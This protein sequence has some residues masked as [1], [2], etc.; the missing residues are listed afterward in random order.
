MSNIPKTRIRRTL[1]G[2]VFTAF[3]GP[4]RHHWE[5]TLDGTTIAEFDNH[6]DALAYAHRRATTAQREHVEKLERAAYEARRAAEK[7]AGATVTADQIRK[8]RDRGHI[9][10]TGKEDRQ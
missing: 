4:A 2:D 8:W 1:V 9:T 6:H 10:D 5:V 7:A 3:F